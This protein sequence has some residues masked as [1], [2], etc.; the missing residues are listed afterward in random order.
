MRSV[1]GL[2]ANKDYIELACSIFELGAPSLNIIDM[3][4][5]CEFPSNEWAKFHDFQMAG[6]S[7]SYTFLAP[8][9]RAAEEGRRDR[10][11]EE[12]ISRLAI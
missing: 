6:V 3:V 12:K 7:T 8:G 1:Y 9:G 4:P 10:A 11:A 2:P 5:I